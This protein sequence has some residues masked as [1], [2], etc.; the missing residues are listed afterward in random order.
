MGF[1]QITQSS[2]LLVFS[3]LILLALNFT[4]ISSESSY[5]LVLLKNLMKNAGKKIEERKKVAKLFYIKRLNTLKMFL[6][7][8]N[9]NYI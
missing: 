6:F 5:M 8:I 1:T 2:K 7:L 4:Q 3:I 9:F